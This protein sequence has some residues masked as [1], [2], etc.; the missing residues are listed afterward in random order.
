MVALGLTSRARAPRRGIGPA[1]AAVGFARCPL[2]R[3]QLARQESQQRRRC[4]CSCG[5]LPEGSEQHPGRPAGPAHRHQ[6]GRFH[7]PSSERSEDS[8]TAMRRGGLTSS[9][10]LATCS[11]TAVRCRRSRALAQ[12]ARRPRP[13]SRSIRRQRRRLA[14]ETLIGQRAATSPRRCRRRRRPAGEAR[15]R[16]GAHA[17]RRGRSRRRGPAARSGR[18]AC[19]PGRSGATR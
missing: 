15:A 8:G 14:W 9:T 7:L 19:R 12:Q 3:G 4:P 16:T 11:K 10:S 5:V 13:R 6:G 17:R 1:L 18:R 2:P